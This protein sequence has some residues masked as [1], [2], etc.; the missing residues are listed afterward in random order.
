MLSH[1]DS[2]D[3]EAMV[4]RE[5][6]EIL[7]KINEASLR[8]AQLPPVM[9]YQS[10]IPHVIAE[11]DLPE[12]VFVSH[13]SAKS[14]Q[15]THPKEESSDVSLPTNVN[16][17]LSWKSPE[18]TDGNPDPESGSARA[19]PRFPPLKKTKSVETLHLLFPGAASDHKGMIHWDDFLATMRELGFEGE[20]RGG[21]EWTFRSV[22]GQEVHRTGRE[23]QKTGWDEQNPEVQQHGKQSIVVHQPHPEPKL[24]A[25]RLQQIGK[26]FRRRFGWGRESFEDL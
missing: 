1:H 6:E 12:K 26:R 2:P 24:G 21:S 17:S 13:T 19:H 25:V 4:A 7:A 20:H 16:Q 15:K 9:P 10:L 18:G 3:Y 22:G 23:D 5:R 11:H 8:K 14:K